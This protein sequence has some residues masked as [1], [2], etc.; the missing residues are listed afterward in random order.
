MVKYNAL[1]LKSEVPPFN[2]VLLIPK[3]TYGFTVN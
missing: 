1:D 2:L 3:G